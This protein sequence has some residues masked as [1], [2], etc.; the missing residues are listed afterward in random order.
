MVEHSN[1]WT[2]DLIERNPV[3][4][5]FLAKRLAVEPQAT[6]MRYGLKAA[7]FC[8]A[9]AVLAAAG[10]FQAAFGDQ[11][12]QYP[13]AAMEY[14]YR[15]KVYDYYG[16]EGFGLLYYFGS[17]R[18]VVVVENDYG[19][20][21]REML[22]RELAEDE[23]KRLTEAIKQA[24][25]EKLAAEYADPRVSDGIQTT[26]TFRLPDGREKTVSVQNV[27]QEQLLRLNQVLNEML[28][29]NLGIGGAR[30]AVA[31]GQ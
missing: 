7:F 30:G 22:S 1:P 5:E 23:R 12:E 19:K 11:Q 2:Q 27:R 14:P 24:S 25:P 29:K 31:V 10:G 17:E 9:V 13:L 21:A 26:Y 3:P 16:A 18:L 8:A 15:L 28:P 6:S 20:P 4:P